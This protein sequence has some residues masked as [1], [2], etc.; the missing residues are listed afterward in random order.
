MNFFTS[1]GTVIGHFF[2]AFFAVILLLARYGRVE[3]RTWAENIIRIGGKWGLEG[4]FLVAF[5]GTA[6][7][8]VY[9][10]IIGFVP[11]YL[12]WIQRIFLYPQVIILGLALW[13]K[14]KD[15]AIYCSVLSVI[16][17]IIALYNFYGQSF[18][19]NAL[20]ECD[21]LGQVSCAVRYFVE[22]GYVTIPVMSLTAFL[23]ILLG[24]HLSNRLKKTNVSL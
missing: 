9:S 17:G 12:C 2:L 16:G 11:C 13:K 19:P 15:A 7:S 14:T 5:T 20:P 6:L 8:L 24:L 4:S 23:L 3:Q 22:F 18:N 21:A 1:L 10:E